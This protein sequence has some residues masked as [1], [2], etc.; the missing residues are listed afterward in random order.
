M[1][2]E[3]DVD[4]EFPLRALFGANLTGENGRHSQS[5]EVELVVAGI[6]EHLLSS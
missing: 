2:S 1:T 5:I 4:K 6:K 3:Q